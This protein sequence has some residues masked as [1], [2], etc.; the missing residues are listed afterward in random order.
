MY[1]ALVNTLIYSEFAKYTEPSELQY[2][3]LIVQNGY[4][5]YKHKSTAYR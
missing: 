2:K 5:F 3:H 4:F 1:M